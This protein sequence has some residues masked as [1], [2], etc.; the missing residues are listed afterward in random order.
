MAHQKTSLG[1]STSNDHWYSLMGSMGL[2]AAVSMNELR[3]GPSTGRRRLAKERDDSK[4]V[5]IVNEDKKLTA[6]RKG[7]ERKTSQPLK[8]RAVA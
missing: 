5:S 7:T 2:S 3:W 8:K 4:E 6:G 1:F